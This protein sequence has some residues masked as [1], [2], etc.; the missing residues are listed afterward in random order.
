MV[1]NPFGASEIFRVLLFQAL[2]AASGAAARPTG[3]FPWH[4]TGF[5][6][7]KIITLR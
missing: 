7:L 5:I 2:R 1:G 3:S 6:A 4:P